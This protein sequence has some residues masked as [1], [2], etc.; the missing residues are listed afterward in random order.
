MSTLG[1]LLAPTK[2]LRAKNDH[3]FAWDWTIPAVVAVIGTL[4][5]LALP[6]PIAVLGDKGLVHWVN[7]LLQILIGFYIASL[8]AVA[9]FDRASLD[10]PIE[11]Q[12]VKL[13]SLRN[14]EYVERSL[15]RRAFISLMF[16]YLSL[17]A[18][19]LYCLGLTVSLLVEN[20]KL[21]NPNVLFYLRGAFVLV[22]GFFFVQMLTVTLVAL[23]YLSDRIH[24]QTPTPL[25]PEDL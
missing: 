10:Q 21:I 23:F 9:S 3:K 16:G 4:C 20:I 24:R 13:R 15:S 14:G 25:P 6:K 7:E 22:Y 17:L 12:G 2:Y 18:I 1:T 5:I 11:G 8:A 19:A